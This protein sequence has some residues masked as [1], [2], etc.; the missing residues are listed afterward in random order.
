MV[1][2]SAPPFKPP[3]LSSGLS[4][5]VRDAVAR[6]AWREVFDTLAAADAQGTLGPQELELMAQAAWWTGQLP[7]A[8][9]A[10]ERAYGMA[11]KAGQPA[12][13]VMSA[14]NLGHNNMLRNDVTI[15]AAWLNR[16]E[17]LLAGMPRNVGHGW[18]A[19]NRSF[20]HALSGNS[21]A[22]LEAATT[23]LDIG[24][25]VGD[26]DLT[27]MAMANKGNALISIG[28]VEAGLA[29]VD[30]AAVS[31]VGGEL[32]PQTAG[33]V[34][35]SGIEACAML[36]EWSRAV[37]WTEAQDR[38]CRREG[39]DGFPGMCRLFRSET[40]QLRGSW[41][42]AEAEARQ[43]SVELLGFMPAGAGS[44][45]YRLGEIKR[46]R[47]DLQAADDALRSAH[48]YSI[49]PEPALS[50]LELAK[51]RPDVA[52][53]GIRRALSDPSPTPSWRA[54]SDSPLYRIPLLRAQVEIALAVNDVKTA[55]EAADELGSIGERFH[56]TATTAAVASARGA[57]ELAEG[58]AGEAA[59]S[60]HRSID[61]WGQVVAPYEVARSRALLAEAYVAADAPERA[62]MELQVAR[63]AFEHV[64][65]IPDLRAAEARLATLSE[66]TEAP[67]PTAGAARV[68]RT[69]VFTDIVDSTKLAELVGDESWSK[70]IRWHD[71]TIRAV[72]AEHGGE[73]IKAT[74]DGFFLA[75]T[76]PR[77]AVQA[78]VAIQRR[79]AAQRD[80]QG[81]APAIRIGLHTAEATRRGLD[82]VGTGVNIAA[83]I[84]A[85]AEGAEI[86]ASEGTVAGLGGSVAVSAARTVN[87]K[88]I[89]EPVE[90]VSIDWR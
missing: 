56:S 14:L 47:G 43:A 72:V 77:A 67:A 90:V 48:A 8:I 76:Q 64:G 23:A 13:A 19:L 11:V 75:F 57:V 74:G 9:E 36:G 65:A 37:A 33:G 7:V 40:K 60:L 51:G 46:L 42:E 70:L 15:A 66:G 55:R 61:L 18:L 4:E 78:V 32:E 16:A 28:E 54:P 62:V 10:R 25:E 2:E 79:L 34:S 30:E 84:G 39:I 31:A 45:F 35:C 71:E 69:F 24:E 81:F 38:W 59:R 3:D 58:D 17:R 87:L 68:T 22:A 26:P 83:R 20:H 12:L 27:A 41:L 21:Q 1:S 80:A 29:L 63:D 50:L 89:G 86:L 5:P 49:D 53:A 82:Y 73:E 6:R 44:A 85:V 88:G 52:A